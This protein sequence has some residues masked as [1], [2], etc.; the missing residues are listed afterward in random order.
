M[1]GVQTCALPISFAKIIQLGEGASGAA[2]QNLNLM[3]GIPE[4]IG[5]NLEGSEDIDI[6]SLNFR[7]RSPFKQ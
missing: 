1:T 5:V 6:R 4:H 3:L 7:P 2:V